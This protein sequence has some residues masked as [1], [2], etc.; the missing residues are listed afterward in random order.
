MLR[1]STYETYANS[2]FFLLEVNPERN[3][4]Q[5]RGFRFSELKQAA[6]EYLEVEKRLGSAKVPGA[7][8]VL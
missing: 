4:L 7:Q 6:D 5:V 2:H 3:T 8:A 1:V